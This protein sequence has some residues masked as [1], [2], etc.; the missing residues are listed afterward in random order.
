MSIKKNYVYDNIISVSLLRGRPGVGG[1][2]R[3][4]NKKI[5]GS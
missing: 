1:E 5:V 3:Y 4:N 2:W